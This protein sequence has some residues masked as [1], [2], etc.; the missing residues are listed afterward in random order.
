MKLLGF[1]NRMH[2][3]QDLF[4]LKTGQS[5]S[6]DAVPSLQNYATLIACLFHPS[7]DH[8]SFIGIRIMSMSHYD[9][10]S[11]ISVHLPA[12]RPPLDAITAHG[13]LELCTMPRTSS[14]ECE[15]ASAIGHLSRAELALTV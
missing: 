6:L 10:P 15:T 7:H 1:V 11:P 12:A 5:E 8:C 13:D 4:I 3:V 14:T 2:S 9:Y